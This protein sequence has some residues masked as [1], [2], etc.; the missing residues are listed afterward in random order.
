MIRKTNL[1]LL[2]HDGEG[3]LVALAGESEWVRNVRAAGGRGRSGG[4]GGGARRRSLRCR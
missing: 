4:P 3:Y 2:E 1:V